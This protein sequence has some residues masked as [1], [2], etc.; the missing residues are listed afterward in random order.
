MMS[1]AVNCRPFHT[2]TDRGHQR[3]AGVSRSRSTEESGKSQQNWSA[4][5]RS[6]STTEFDI[7]TAEGD[8]VTISIAARE[9]F[10]AS[11]SSDSSGQST[12]MN[13]SSSSKVKVEIQ[14][15]LNEAEMKEITNLIGALGK[16]IGTAQQTGTI[17]S[18]AL[19]D[20]LAKSS[21]LSGFN[22]AYRQ[23][24]IGQSTFSAVG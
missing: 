10:A 4:G 3:S 19:S 2:D 21:T 7:R 18:Q 5:V 24:V 8:R 9:R 17:D 13:A 20:T 15:D 11:S 12:A 23:Q 22:F 1:S 16:S 6:K 14:G